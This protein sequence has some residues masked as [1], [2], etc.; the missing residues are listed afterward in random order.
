[1]RVGEEGGWVKVHNKVVFLFGIV[2]VMYWFV[3]MVLFP[4]I[5]TAMMV[6]PQGFTVIYLLGGLMFVGLSF[7]DSDVKHRGEEQVTA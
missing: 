4:E 5:G 7:V 3:V 1:M 2:C 6:K